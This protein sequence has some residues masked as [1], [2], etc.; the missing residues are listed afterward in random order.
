MKRVKGAY[1]SP[2]KDLLGHV[3]VVVGLGVGAQLGLEAAVDVHHWSRLANQSERRVE[4]HARRGHDEGGNE[5][6]GS[7]A[8]TETMNEN[9]ARIRSLFNRIYSKY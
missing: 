6:S 1:P 9:T 7:T 4:V 3:D 2:E 8:T 5:S